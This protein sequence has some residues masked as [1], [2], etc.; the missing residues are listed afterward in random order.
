MSRFLDDQF[1]EQSGRYT[2]EID[3]KALVEIRSHPTRMSNTRVSR[4]FSEFFLRRVPS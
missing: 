2:N 1:D 3:E 4:K